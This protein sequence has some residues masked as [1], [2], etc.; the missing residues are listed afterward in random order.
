MISNL[1]LSVLRPSS[2]FCFWSRSGQSKVFR[3]FAA[4]MTTWHSEMPR[5]DLRETADKS[6]S[7]GQ[8]FYSQEYQQH[9]ESA[10]DDPESFWAEAAQEI[11]WYKQ[12]DTV[13][14]NK[15]PPFA[16]WFP[17]GLLNV[18]H[19]AVDRHVDAGLGDRLAIIH[20]SPVTNT[21]RFITYRQLQ[22]QVSSLAGTFAQW[23]IRRGDR[24][25]IYM[26][27]I[28]EAIIAML[29]CARI[30]AIHSVVFGGF[31]ARELA[32]RMNHTE[33]KLVIS[34]SYG[35]EPNR[36]IEYKPILEEAIHLCEHKPEKC[37]I[38]NRP[39]M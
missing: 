37:I 7:K 34:A 20:D 24:V 25:V 4:G 35:V 27:M 17:G 38:Y 28:P 19:N 39:E 31:A 6:L 8:P 30:G 13:L 22:D 29:A 15:N 5:V 10:R 33:P 32:I 21:V 18:C 23:N 9:F 1:T 3:L 11:T 26:P 16:K 14:D 36:L 2:L 12:W